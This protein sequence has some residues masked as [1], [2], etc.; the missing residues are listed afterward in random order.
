[1]T[2][3]L[4][5]KDS[6]EKYKLL[7]FVNCKSKFLIVWQIQKNYIYFLIYTVIHVYTGTCNQN[8]PPFPLSLLFDQ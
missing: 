2:V 5:E 6:V 1:M 8:L 7:N 3:K 4:T